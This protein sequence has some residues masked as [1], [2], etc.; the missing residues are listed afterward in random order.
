M[1]EINRTRDEE[2]EME[3]EVEV[4]GRSNEGFKFQ[5]FRDGANPH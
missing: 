2:V 5:A 1:M 3:V 4:D